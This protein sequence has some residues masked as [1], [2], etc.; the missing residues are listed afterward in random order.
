V[1]AYPVG[2]ITRTYI[3]STGVGFTPGVPA[4]FDGLVHAQS[5]VEP[6]YRERAAASAE[7]EAA[8]EASSRASQQA[9]QRSTPQPT[10]SKD[11]Q[12][13]LAGLTLKPRS[14]PLPKIT[15]SEPITDRKSQ[16]VGHACAIADEE[17]VMAVV[18]HLLE[19]KR[20]ARAAHPTIWAYR[21]VRDA[22]GAA[23]RI[24]E[25][26]E[27]LAVLGASLTQTTTTTG[28]RRPARASNTS[29]RSWT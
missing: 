14:R 21:T 28:R 19:D 18:G 22:G 4:V 16:F 6:W 3:S 25:S 24:V 17:D 29:S 1:R 5:L 20:I 23:G 27:S 8:H 26:G 9:S 2:A 15:T 10:A 11:L 7:A 13:A 12:A